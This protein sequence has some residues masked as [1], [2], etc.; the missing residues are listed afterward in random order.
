MLVDVV[1]A[2]VL[3]SPLVGSQTGAR[4]QMEQLWRAC[5]PRPAR[6][7]RLRGM[8]KKIVL[9]QEQIEAFYKDRFAPADSAIADASWASS[10]RRT[11]SASAGQVQ[12][13]DPETVG[14]G[15]VE[16]EADFSGDYLQLVRF[17]NA[18]ERPKLFFMV[19]SV[20]LA[21]EQRGVVKLEMKLKVISRAGA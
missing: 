2:A 20:S 21:G 15:Q 10:R 1:A 14:I 13:E 17:I 9:A 8:D 6:S 5:T 11:A 3:F 12:E 16:I 19:D 18:L 4:Q 7:N